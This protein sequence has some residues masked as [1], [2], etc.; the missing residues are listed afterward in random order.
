MFRSGI[1]ILVLSFDYFT[2]FTYVCGFWKLSLW[3]Y[4]HYKELN[5]ERY[6]S[7]KL[8]FALNKNKR[9]WCDYFVYSWLLHKLLI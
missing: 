9:G 3:F 7:E 8:F 1:E 6:V 2:F 5:E 4:K